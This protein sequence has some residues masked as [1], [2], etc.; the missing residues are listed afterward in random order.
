M[1]NCNIHS[2]KTYIHNK[3]FVHYFL[4]IYTS[5]TNYLMPGNGRF[6]LKKLPFYDAKDSILSYKRHCLIMPKAT[7]RHYM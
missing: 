7:F 4:A 2:I 3:C 1:C 6:A 5:K